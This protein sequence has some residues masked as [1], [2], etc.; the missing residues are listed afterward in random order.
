MLW[1]PVGREILMTTRRAALVTG[2]SYGVGAATALA[3]AQE[4]FDVAVAAT[5]RE[6]LAATV[7]TLEAA[8]ARA[9]VATLDLQSEE[10]VAQASAEVIAALG[11]LDVLV[12][13]AGV[14][15][16]K[17]A[18]AVTRQEW[19][20]GDECEPA[21]HVFSHPADRPPSHWCK[22]EGASSLSPRPMRSSA[23]RSA[24]S[25]AFPRRL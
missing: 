10:S 2:A 6:H 14:N 1:S 15:L 17:D 9:V 19:D 25:T 3:L 22:G 11:G 12:N 21:R 24:P 20:A 5:K 8:G 4:G 16:R 13:N 18:T 23:R 7:K